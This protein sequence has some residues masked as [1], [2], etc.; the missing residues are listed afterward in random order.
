[1]CT[2]LDGSVGIKDGSDWL[3]EWDDVGGVWWDSLS[4]DDELWKACWELGQMCWNQGSGAV[5]GGVDGACDCES[6]VR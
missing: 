3:E 6:N 1:M 4:V 2:L 5:S